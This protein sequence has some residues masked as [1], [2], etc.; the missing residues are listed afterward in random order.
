MYFVLFF[1]ESIRCISFKSHKTWIDPPDLRCPCH[2]CLSSRGHLI[3][4]EVTKCVRP[5]LPVRSWRASGPPDCSS[6][7]NSGSQEKASPA[8]THRTAT[9]IG[10]AV[11]PAVQLRTTA[12]RVNEPA[13]PLLSPAR[14]GPSITNPKA[15]A[16]CVQR[17]P[18]LPN[19]RASLGGVRT[20]PRAGGG[21]RS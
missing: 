4:T 11:L 7:C 17:P 20:L 18:S 14:M 9:L 16:S 1:L 13:D 6:K 3:S 2:T 21:R 5:G 12:G 10:Q 19:G 8:P 15:P